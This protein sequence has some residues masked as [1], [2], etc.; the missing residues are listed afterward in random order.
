MLPFLP[1]LPHCYRNTGA[2]VISTSNYKE[3]SAVLIQCPK[4]FSIPCIPDNQSQA[5]CHRRTSSE[6]FWAPCVA[7]NSTMSTSPLVVLFQ[8]TLCSRAVMTLDHASRCSFNVLKPTFSGTSSLAK[9]LA[10]KDRSPGSKHCRTQRTRTS[11]D[12]DRPCWLMTTCRRLNQLPSAMM[13]AI[14]VKSRRESRV[15]GLI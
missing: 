2:S 11:S 14:R 6:C 8:W 3:V 10:R 15:P 4:R 13:V 1:T 9:L 5:S 7:Q 12:T